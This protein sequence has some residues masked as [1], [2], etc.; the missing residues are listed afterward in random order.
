MQS[1][2]NLSDLLAVRDGELAD[3]AR[4]EQ[5]YADPQAREALAA[6][7]GLKAELRALP[8][9]EPDAAV[10]DAIA[11]RRRSAWLQRFPLATAATV[12]LAAAL[13]VVWW[14]PTGS[15]E[16]AAEPLIAGPS[17]SDPVAQLVLRSQQLESGLLSP[18]AVA[19]GTSASE[20]ALLFAIADVDAQLSALYE[21]DT[22]D[23]E[24]RERL[25][26]Q[27]VMLLESLADEQRG[28]A[29]TRPAIF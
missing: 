20:R 4:V 16:R 28:R 2:P 5:I 3:P 7:A 26:R 17:V 18:A 21:S 24:Q 8:G 19:S 13:S 11:R 14:N 6:L 10:W 1:N 9:I 27:R 23:P 29:S 15:G 12:F 22:V 25:W